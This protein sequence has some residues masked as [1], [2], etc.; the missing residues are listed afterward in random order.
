MGPL[1]S[2]KKLSKNVLFPCIETIRSGVNADF[3]P[4]LI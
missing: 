3:I 2:N 1:L 4:D